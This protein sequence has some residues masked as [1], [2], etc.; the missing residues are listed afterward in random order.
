[1]GIIIHLFVLILNHIFLVEQVILEPFLL[2][3]DP[4]FHCFWEIQKRA[5]KEVKSLIKIVDFPI[6]LSSEEGIW[7]N[8][9]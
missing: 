4:I 3:I 1:M 6:K 7:D 9:F 5:S 8:G 2:E